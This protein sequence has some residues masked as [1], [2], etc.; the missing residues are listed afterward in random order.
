MKSSKLNIQN[1]KGLKLQAYLELPANQKP[2]YF[3]IFAHCFTCTSSLSA[4]KNISRALT[5]H[6]FGVVRFDF[7]GLGRSEGE[8]AESHFSANVED[9]I[10]VSNYMDTHY[11]APSL[12]VGHSLGGAAVLSAASQLDNIKAIATIGAPAT[13]G[14]VTHLFSHG[15]DEVKTKGEVEVNIGGRPFKINKD[16]VEDFDKTDL[17]A[18]VKTLRKPLLILHA[19]TDTVVGIKNAEQLYHHAHH[20]KSFVTLDDAD[21]LLSNPNDSKYAGNVIGTWVQRYFELKENKMLETKGEQLVGHLNLVED[22]FTT[23]IQTKKHTMIADEPSSVGGDDFGPS[24][25][26]YLNAGLVAC[27]AMTLKMYA[28]RKQWDLQEVFVYVTHSRKHSD[29][30]GL[31]IETPTY[32]D[33]I[34]K[35]LKFVGN[36][37]EKQKERLKEI[38]SKCPVHK[39]IASEVVFNTTIVND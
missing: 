9:L 21:H 7:T 15:I 16:F 8:F 29:D 24:P 32:L 1:N 17:P 33:H 13:V 18:I 3:A 36:L 28:Q 20:P 6:G 11:E 27:T 39:T 30:L 37:D 23:S 14:H 4:V 12:L 26:E 34:S 38:A 31:E 19:P 25:Y 10:A 22:N 2:N 35:K 5:N